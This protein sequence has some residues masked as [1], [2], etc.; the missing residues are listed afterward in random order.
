[1]IMLVLLSVG[2]ANAHGT[3]FRYSGL[4]AVPLEFFYSDGEKMSYLEAKVFSPADE[5]FPAQTGR[6]DEA[7]RFAFVPDIS[8]DWRVIVRDEQG[9]QC[10]AVI[11]VSGQDSPYRPEAEARSPE[12]V[13]RALLGV[14]LLFNIAFIVRR[15]YAHQ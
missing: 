15:R 9:H 4:R 11:N 6:T 8:G 7:G 10:T 13:V 5:K 14:S 3:G 1:M 2:T 12:L